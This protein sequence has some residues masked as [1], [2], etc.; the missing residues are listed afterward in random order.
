[1]SNR[2]LILQ[3]KASKENAEILARELQEGNIDY[4]GSVSQTTIVSTQHAAI[5]DTWMKSYGTTKSAIRH[6]NTLKNGTSAS[7]TGNYTIGVL[8]E[9]SEFTLF[10]L[11][12]SEVAS[13][14]SGKRTYSEYS[15]SMEFSSNVSEDLKNLVRNHP[16]DLAVLVF[17]GRVQTLELTM[18]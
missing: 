8:E 16:V 4:R 7:S 13:F 12:F 1:M 14:W 15:V 9:G 2:K 6:I 3:V 11:H 18:V 5:L 17:T 10:L